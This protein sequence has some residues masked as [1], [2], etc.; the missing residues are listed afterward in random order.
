MKV[1]NYHNINF[2]VHGNALSIDIIDA[3]QFE[4]KLPNDYKQ[5]L[6]HVN[7]AE[8]ECNVLKIDTVHYKNIVRIEKF[9]GITADNE[10]N[11]LYD[12]R[13]REYNSIIQNDKFPIAY[14]NAGN[15]IFI[16]LKFNNIRGKIYYWDHD[17][18]LCSDE[19]FNPNE[20]ICLANSFDEFLGMLYK[21][22][23]IS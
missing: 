9:L 14:D 20:M 10:F 1:I 17:Y 21:D 19:N 11:V 12:L 8:P 6:L 23:A 3:M 2:Y 18:T 7:A 22:D 13:Y 16:G 15:T 4:A 5:F